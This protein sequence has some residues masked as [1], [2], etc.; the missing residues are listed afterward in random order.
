MTQEFF[1]PM[2]L[3]PTTLMVYPGMFMTACADI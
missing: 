3:S 2:M 1:N